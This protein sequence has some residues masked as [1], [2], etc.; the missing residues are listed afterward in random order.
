[1]EEGIMGEEKHDQN[2]F[3]DKICSLFTSILPI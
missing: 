3:I 1:M 2:T